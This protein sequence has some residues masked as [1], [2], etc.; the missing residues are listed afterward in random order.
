VGV[1]A[2]SPAFSSAAPARL[3]V[4]N[5]ATGA[6]VAEIASASA[7]DLDQ[8]MSRAR[9]AQP[10]WAALSFRQRGQVLRRLSGLLVRDEGLMRTLMAENGK[11]RYEAEAIELF[12][13]AELTRFLTGRTG[14]R[15]LADQVRRPFIFAYKR[16]RVVHHP[17]GVVG[18]IGPW[19]WPLLNNYADCVA[20]LAAGN[21]VILK[22]SPLTPLTSLRVAALWGGLSRELG[23][24]EGIFQVLAGGAELGQAL[25]DLADMIF[26]TGSQHVGR[27]VASR[28]GQRLIPVVVELGG[29]SPFIV[30]ADADL[31]AAARAAVWGA[32]ANSGQVCI[33]PERFLVEA[34][35]AAAFAERCK[36]ELARLRQG[37]DNDADGLASQRADVDVGAMTVQAQVD[38]VEQQIAAAVAAGAQV[39][40]GGKRR[41]DLGG[42]FFQPTILTGVTAAMAVAREET[43]GPILPIIEVRD[44]EEAVTI[45]NQL[46]MGLSGSVFSGSARRGAALARRLETGSVCVNDALVNYFC[47][48]APLGGVKGSGLGVRHGP[49]ALRQFAR[50]ETIV[51]DDP[52]L[53][54]VGRW[55]GDQLR[56]PYQTRVLRLIRR[57]MRW[58]Y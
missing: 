15:A 9:L 37:P 29:K 17:H 44:A 41:P 2:S 19:N 26:F 57:V 48:E 25:V 39:V 22:P 47:V 32:F 8:A 54:G 27:Q 45:A 36:L 6:L 11:P 31:A 24:P 42:R 56:F 49:E 5:P 4:E 40:A 20:P 53:G 12:Y 23:L 43:F 14:R 34:P 52:V 35:V 18:V 7:A 10:A 13:T 55:V 1:G 58:L 28:C 46:G 30:L 16:A 38:T 51:E 33:R 21:A 50:L 3:R